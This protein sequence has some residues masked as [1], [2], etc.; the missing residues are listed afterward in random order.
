MQGKNGIDADVPQMLHRRGR[1]DA[2]PCAG[3][4]DMSQRVREVL[5]STL[6]IA[7]FGSSQ[8]FLTRRKNVG[9]GAP[10]AR[11]IARVG[12]I[13]RRIEPPGNTPDRRGQGRSAT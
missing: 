8:A 9:S 7:R 10:N 5:E 12:H 3:Y 2:T 13:G 1:G 6:N 11:V 4:P